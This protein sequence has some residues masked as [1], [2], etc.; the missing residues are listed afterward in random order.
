[1]NSGVFSGRGSSIIG[2]IIQP[3]NHPSAKSNNTSS[4]KPNVNMQPPPL[5]AAR[6]L[7]LGTLL[8]ISATSFLVSCIFF[9]SDCHSVDELVSTWRSWA[10]KK[11]R[12]FESALGIPVERSARIEY[13]NDVKGMSEDEEW[14]YVKQKYGSEIRWEGNA[15]GDKESEK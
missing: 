15:D 7:A 1:M 6:A 10:P 3:D 2:Q 13:E 4:L 9:A 11:L 12:E 8:S 5:L 14:E